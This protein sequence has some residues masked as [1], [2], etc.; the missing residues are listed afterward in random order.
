[1]GMMSPVKPPF[2]LGVDGSGV[3]EALGS[4]VRDFQ[5]GD[6]VFFYTGL[7]WSGTFA[8]TVVVDARACAAKPHSGLMPKRRRQLWLFCVPTWHRNAHK[9]MLGSEC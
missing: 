1:M 7:V 5:V 8:E 4:E 9:Y 6:E 3:V 2:T